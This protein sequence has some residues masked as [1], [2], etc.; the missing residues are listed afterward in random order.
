MQSCTKRANLDQDVRNCYSQTLQ[1]LISWA[2]GVD[3]E[4]EANNLI[5]KDSFF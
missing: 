1:G 3:L 5:S 2:K 4:D